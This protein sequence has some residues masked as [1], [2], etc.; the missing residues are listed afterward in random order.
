MIDLVDLSRIADEEFDDVSV[1]AGWGI[2]LVVI[3]GL[4]CFIASLVAWKT[5]KAPTPTE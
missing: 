5:S 2:W 1:T 4:G 3:G